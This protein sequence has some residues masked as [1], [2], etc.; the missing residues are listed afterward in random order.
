MLANRQARRGT[1]MCDFTRAQAHPCKW[2]QLPITPK[3]HEHVHWVS[4]AVS[5]AAADHL[6]PAPAKN[7]SLARTAACRSPLLVGLFQVG[8]AQDMA[9]PLLAGCEHFPPSGRRHACA[10]PRCASARPAV[11]A[12][13]AQVRSAQEQPPGKGSLG[14]HQ[15]CGYQ[16]TPHCRPVQPL[17]VS[18]HD[19]GEPT[20]APPRAAQV[21]RHRRLAV[22]LGLHLPPQRLRRAPRGDQRQACGVSALN[23]LCTDTPAFVACQALV[24]TSQHCHIVNQT[25]VLH[26]NMT[27]SGA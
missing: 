2:H 25:M 18:S 11:M 9:A 6:Q 27:S 3:L 15:L 24:N 1:C 7:A 21:A 8:W 26:I 13:R 22:C 17:R 12:R 10:V 4:R 20:D 16:S 19:K 5:R 14:E 23:Q